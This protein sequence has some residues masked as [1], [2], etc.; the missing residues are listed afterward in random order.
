MHKKLYPA[1][2]LILCWFT[3]LVAHA[4]EKIDKPGSEKVEMAD[5]LRANGKI[6]VVVVV[7]LV[8]L[9]GLFAYVIRL[10][11]KINHLEKEIK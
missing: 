7:L 1:L 10:D 6:Y 11:R 8:I 5:T 3:G 4:Q 9:V 2:F